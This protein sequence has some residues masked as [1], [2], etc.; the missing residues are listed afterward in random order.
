MNV[1]NQ[2]NEAYGYC[3]QIINKHSKTFSKAFS[4]LPKKQKQAVW[5]IYAFCR[6]VDD[7]VDEGENPKVELDQFELD[8]KVFLNGELPNE[9][10]MW[11]ALSDVFTSF[12]MDP[13]PF[14]EM[15]DGQR[16]DITA[17]DIKTNEQL[18][19][20]CY[21]VASTVGLMLLPVLA[22][23]KEEKLR[24]GAVSLGIGMQLTNILR[25]IG[26][27]LERD[28][29]YIP[30]ELMLKHNY[31][32]EDLQSHVINSSFISLWE[33]MAEQAADYY[34]EA[35]QTIHE[36]PL[37]SRTPVQGATYL[38]RA[39]LPSIRKNRYQVFIERNYV[40]DQVKREIL[41]EMR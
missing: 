30:E 31:S 28:R 6:Q 7:I 8:F 1:V 23:G 2:L 25:D 10:L 20:Y 35:L 3:E 17:N 26:E 34:H 16:M 22:P 38:Y 33:D 21:L 15:I 29:I 39:I 12:D 36:Y 5:A 27:D 40:S 41:A 37:Y 4:L 14:Q 32:Y 9:D 19:Y 13:V 18:H 11:Y 24:D